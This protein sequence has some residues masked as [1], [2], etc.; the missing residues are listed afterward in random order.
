LLLI[1]LWRRLLRRL[2]ALGGRIWRCGGRIWRCGWRL[3]CRRWLL[4]LVACR[5]SDKGDCRNR[6]RKKKLMHVSI[7]C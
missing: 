4:G 5:Q 6:G 3:W 1:L 2:L 7:L